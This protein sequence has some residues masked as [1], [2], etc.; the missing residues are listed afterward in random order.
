V[1]FYV[2]EYRKALVSNMDGVVGPVVQPQ[3]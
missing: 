3:G 1:D 2:S